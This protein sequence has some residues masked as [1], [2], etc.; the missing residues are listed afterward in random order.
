M[1]CNHIWLSALVDDYQS[2]NTP[3]LEKK[4]GHQKTNTLDSV[5]LGIRKASVF[6][7]LGGLDWTISSYTVNT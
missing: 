1:T 3:Q 7:L 5:L 6:V 4:I 2:T